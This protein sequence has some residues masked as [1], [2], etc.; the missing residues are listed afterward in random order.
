MLWDSGEAPGLGSALYRRWVF[1]AGTA[2]HS[3][4]L[5]YH[6]VRVILSLRGNDRQEA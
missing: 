4:D 3:Q 1:G 5:L 6:T 2:T